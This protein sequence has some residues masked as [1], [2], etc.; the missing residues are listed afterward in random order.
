M[1]ATAVA[2][3]PCKRVRTF[4]QSLT[5]T[6]LRIIEAEAASGSYRQAHL[7]AFSGTAGIMTYRG[8]GDAIPMSEYATIVG[9]VAQMVAVLLYLNHVIASWREEREGNRSLLSL[10]S[11]SG[12]VVSHLPHLRVVSWYH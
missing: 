1:A 6:F 4:R 11:R 2:S 3:A 8:A 9:R 5:T 10:H 12:A 7:S